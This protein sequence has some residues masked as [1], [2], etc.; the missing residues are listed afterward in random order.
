L[1]EVSHR[2]QNVID[3]QR[4]VV[5]IHR[6]SVVDTD[7]DRQSVLARTSNRSRDVMARIEWS[8]RSRHF[9]HIRRGRNGSQFASSTRRVPFTSR[10]QNSSIRPSSWL[11]PEQ[12]PPNSGAVQLLSSPPAD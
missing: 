6:T 4:A 8:R 9:R 10:I 1:S 12:A 7:A 2:Q 11:Y 3:S 5:L